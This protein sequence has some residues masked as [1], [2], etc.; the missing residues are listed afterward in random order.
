MNK[1]VRLAKNVI[2]RKV[3]PR[4][5]PFH[6]RILAKEVLRLHAIRNR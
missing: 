5:A 1:A 2:A 4:W 6:A 3:L